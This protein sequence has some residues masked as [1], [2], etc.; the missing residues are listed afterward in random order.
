[1]RIASRL[2]AILVTGTL[3]CSHA[4]GQPSQPATD[5]GPITAAF[6][7]WQ[8]RQKAVR[9]ARYV[10]SGTVEFLRPDVHDDPPIPAGE[11]TKP[12]TAT[13]LLDLHD[14][15][16]RIE[17]SHDWPARDGKVR[18]RSGIVTFNGVEARQGRP[19]EIVEA[20]GG[21]DILISKKAPDGVTGGAPPSELWPMLFA[22]GVIPTI[23]QP[24][25]LHRLT[26]PLS[27]DDFVSHGRH[28]LR[29]IPCQLLRTEPLMGSKANIDEYWVQPERRSA[30]VRYVSLTDDKPWL[31][32][33]IDWGESEAGWMPRKWT[34]AYYTP[35]GKNLTRLHTLKVDRFEVNP[36][37]SDAD[38]TIPAVPGM[39]EVIV[40]EYPPEG[41]RVQ[42]GH[43]GRRTYRIADDGEWILTDSQGWK[44]LDGTPIP[45]PSRWGWW[46]W[47]VGGVGLVLGG[48]AVYRW[49]RRRA[50]SHPT[51]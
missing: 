46:P 5:R 31:R 41:V 1:M 10:V 28:A 26:R 15:R 21:F 29:G 40:A 22:H 49:R 23:H 30:V 6:A 32:L 38:F 14:N 39:K 33:D 2:I 47:A 50:A 42:P 19:R 37:V 35:D 24:I 9:T 34:H 3:V 18:K 44:A 51:T 11:Q 43:V 8:A 36:T 45:L 25:D 20:Q 12:F 16:C 48:W 17:F 13:V 27:S 7:G 4:V